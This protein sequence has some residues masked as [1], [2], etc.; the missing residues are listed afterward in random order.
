MPANLDKKDMFKTMEGVSVCTNTKKTDARICS[1]NRTIAL[2]SHASKVLLKV[3]QHRLDI[4]MDQ[5]MAIEQAGFMKER[6]TRYQISN[7]RWMMERSIEYQRPIY[8]CFVDYSKAVDCV[9]HPMLWN[10]MEEMGIPEH[11]FF[12]CTI[13]RSF[14]ANQEAKLRTG[15]SDT[16]SFS[17]GKGVRQGCVPSPYLFNLYSEYIMRQAN[18][19]EL[20]IGVRMGGRKINNLRY[21]DDTTLLAE[22]K[23]E[24]LQL[25]TSVKEK[26][27]QAG[28]LLKPGKD[29]G[30]VY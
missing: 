9:D 28:L 12:Y 4:Y 15:Y 5:E 17:I 8:M 27:A 23:E 25:V 3:I 2:I 10:M 30:D 11:N 16:E 19:E 18:L 14:F 7:L 1:N 29:Q 22:S 20:A 13:I 6:G 26:S 21:A 24:L